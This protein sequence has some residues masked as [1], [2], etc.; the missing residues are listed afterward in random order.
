MQYRL[1]GKQGWQ[2]SALGFGCMR[3]PTID[4]KSGNINEEEAIRMI[5]F[6]IEQGVNYFDTAFGYH[7]RQSEIVV[8]K[9]LS[10]GWRDKVHLVTKLPMWLVEAQDDYDRFLEEQL[11]KLQTDHLDVYLF[12]GLGKD[13]WE[14][15]QRLNLLEKAEKAVADGRIGAVGFSFHDNVDAFKE[16]IDG[17]DRWAMAQIQ[18]NYMD[19]ENQAGTEGLRYAGERG[20][21]VVVM[22]PLLGGKLART[23]P[24]VEPLWADYAAVKPETTGRTPAEWALQW[25]WDQPE[26][27]V[28]LSGMST[29]EQVEQNIAFADR[30]IVG[31]MTSEDLALIAAVRETINQRSPIPCT[32]CEYCLPCPNGVAIPRN[33]AVY[34]EGAMYD[35]PAGAR[36]AYKRWIGDSE[37]ASVCIACQECESKCP[38]KIE[39]SRWMP[40]VEEVL[41]LGRDYVM[42]L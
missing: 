27:T 3:L 25:L 41:G 1:F 21:A 17:Y 22:E 36:F 9:A 39:I 28:A 16:I 5:H 18:Y 7:E 42:K 13:S 19:V 32:S 31:Q 11:G 24:S 26:V 4:G 10:G 30:S 37:K 38:Q 40:V 23:I 8:G 12:H 6:A 2:V 15:V 35:D 34:N 14:K 20:I 33:F 29:F